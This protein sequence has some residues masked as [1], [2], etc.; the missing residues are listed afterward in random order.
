MDT[1][2]IKSEEKKGEKPSLNTQQKKDLERQVDVQGK[3]GGTVTAEKPIN[4][5]KDNEDIDEADEEE[6]SSGKGK[7]CSK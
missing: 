4:K 1:K 7:S 5:A 6:K 2:N 3:H